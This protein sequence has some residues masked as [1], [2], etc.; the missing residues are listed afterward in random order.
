MRRVCVTSDIWKGHKVARNNAYKMLLNIL[1]MN[2]TVPNKV[3][4]RN[5]IL[6]LVSNTLESWEGIEKQRYLEIL[7][8]FR[9]KNPYRKRTHNQVNP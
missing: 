6:D 5:F 8:S 7:K 1:F 3:E 2:S 9:H 4:L